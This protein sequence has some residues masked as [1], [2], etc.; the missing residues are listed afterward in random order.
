MAVVLS[1]LSFPSGSTACAG[2]ERCPALSWVS[3]VS[4]KARAVLCRAV[5]APRAVP[6]RPRRLRAGHSTDT[7]GR[8][9]L[10]PGEP[11]GRG[12]PRVPP[13]PQR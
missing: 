10:A 2:P 6:H 4:P 8:E 13:R 11:G 9:L 7:S 12:V 1:C 3:P 5:L